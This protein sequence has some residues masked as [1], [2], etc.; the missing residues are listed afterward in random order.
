M[1][2]TETVAEFA[3]EV[4]YAGLPEGVREAAKLRA[5]DA[6][7]VGVASLGVGPTDAV[8]RAVSAQ[9]ATGR[10][11]LWGSELSASPPDAAMYNAGLVAAGNGPV[12]LAP[13]PTAV[14]DAVAAV[15]AAAE[16]RSATGEAVLAGLGVAFE[17]RGELAWNVPL[18]GFHPATHGAV[19][20]AAGVGRTMGLAP[21][22]LADAVGLAGTHAT[23]AV[24]DGE[25]DPLAAGTAALTGVYACLLA[26]GGVDGPDPLGEAGGWPDLVGGFDLDLDPGCERVAD[27]ALLPHAGHP[28]AQTAV[29]AAV[30]VA[31]DVA[32]DPADV[33]A[34]RVETFADAVPVVGAVEIAAALVDRGLSRRPADRADL[35]PVADVVEVTDRAELTERAERG[36]APARVVVECRDGSVQEAD[37]QWFTG[38][39]ARPASWG[40]VEEKFH[41]VAGDRYDADRRSAIVETVRGFEAETAAELSRL[42]D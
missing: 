21:D 15:L 11:R 25:T 37:R 5:L 20:A 12:F 14:G 17:V 3:T 40:T 16:A 31:E 28:Y 9:N 30:D 10:S 22:V 29:E 26:E 27:A 42:L 32:V 4:T 39:P 19:A 13:T 8:R 1:T 24:G 41:A 33:E 7:G 2:S 6:V 34:V 35:R 18:D 23:L 38:H 36:E